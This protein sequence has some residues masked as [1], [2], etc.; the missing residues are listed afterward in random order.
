MAKTTQPDFISVDDVVALLDGDVFLLDVRE[1]DE[2]ASWKIP[3]SY[4]IPLGELA[5][6]L[7]EIPGARPVV[8]VC[9]KGARA[10]HASELLA[11]HG[12]SSRVLEDGMSAWGRAYDEVDIDFPGAVVTQIRRRGKGCLSYVI[13]SGSRAVVIDPSSDVERYLR[14][15]ERHGFTIT[16]VFDT[17]LHADHL[18]GARDL[19]GRTGATLVLNPADPFTYEFSPITDG[20]RVEISDALHLVVSAVTAPGH[21]EGSTVYRL[22]DVALFTGD[23]LFLESVGRPDLADHAEAFAHSL[24]R[25]LHEVVLPLDDDLLVFPAHY[26]DAVEVHG[27]E[28][29][30][31]SLGDLRRDLPALALSEDEFVAWAVARVSDRP[32]NYR[33]IVKFNAGHS[34]LDLTA[35]HDLELGPNRCAIAS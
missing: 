16:H 26:G 27:G 7:G 30:T 3:G 8:T 24:Y 4:N 29:V 18:S 1:P 6:R 15:A 22:G 13:G 19:A 34:S 31:R 32:P 25:S 35:L 5:E 33:E 12:M 9:A 20:L 28:P 2:V 23:T 21:T 10:L 14:V 11:Q 17:H